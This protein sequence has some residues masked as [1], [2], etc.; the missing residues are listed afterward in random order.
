MAAADGGLAEAFAT[1]NK[2]RV[3]PPVWWR[4]K[5]TK[6]LTLRFVLVGEW[7]DRGRRDE[8]ADV[9]ANPAGTEAAGAAATLENM[10]LFSARPRRS[11]ALAA[12]TAKCCLSSCHR[13]RRGSG[14]NTET[15]NENS[16]RTCKPR[17]TRWFQLRPRRCGREQDGPSGTFSTAMRDRPTASPH[18]HP[19]PPPKLDLKTGLPTNGLTPPPPRCR[20]PWL[21]GCRAPCRRS[22]RCLSPRQRPPKPPLLLPLL[23]YCFCPNPLLR[24][25]HDRTDTKPIPPPPQHGPRVAACV[26]AQWPAPLPVALA[27]SAPWPSRGAAQPTG[28]RPPATSRRSGEAR[29]TSANASGSAA[30]LRLCLVAGT[31]GVEAALGRRR[32]PLPTAPAHAAPTHGPRH[33]QP[34]RSSQRFCCSGHLRAL[35]IYLQFLFAHPIF[36]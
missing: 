26:R 32:F 24:R 19:Q 13:H 30:A 20:R 14:T 17:Q 35:V 6:Y 15:R 5:Q 27:E 7:K 34:W 8:A 3:R 31:V 33:R 10:T 36:L 1:C 9:N 16:P 29:A 21:P 4:L 12:P 28:A 22:C 18:P 2:A 25:R 11:R 23:L